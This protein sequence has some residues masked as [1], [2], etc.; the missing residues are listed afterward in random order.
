MFYY[1]RP[2]IREV[3]EYRRQSLDEKDARQ[4]HSLP[5]QAE[6]NAEFAERFHL[7]IVDS[8]IDGASAKLPNNRP[9]FTA[10]LKELKIKNPAL[11]RADGILCWHPDRLSRN[12][13]EAG[14]LVQMIVDEQIKDMFFPTYHFH[15]DPS[16]IEHLM[17]EFGRAISYSGWLSINSK[18]GSVG[19]ERQGAWVYGAPNLVIQKSVSA[20]NTPSAFPFSR[21]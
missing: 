16:G 8:F 1:E 5:L 12:G 7:K 6:F 10:M 15:N 17:M 19:R 21:S 4:T 2:K 20:R 13:L 14:Q 3:F 18:R 11:R 9:N